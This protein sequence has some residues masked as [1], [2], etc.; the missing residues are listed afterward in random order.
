MQYV[1]TRGTGVVSLTEAMAAGLAPDGGLFLPVRL[2]VLPPAPKNV[3]SLASV[4][5]WLLRPFFAD[6]PLE[7][8]VDAICA[9]AFTFP[10]PTR[11]LEPETELLEL[12]HGPTAAFKDFGARFLAECTARMPVEGR[13]LAVLVATSCDTG[14]AVAAAFHSLA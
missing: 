5:S 7:A 9:S 13:V 8:H 6:E 14:A 12:F 4:A 10:A 11:W 3:D 1:S 2:P